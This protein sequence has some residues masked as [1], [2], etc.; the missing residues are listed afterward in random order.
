MTIEE[1]LAN[2]QDKN[3]V[4]IKFARALYGYQDTQEIEREG[5][6]TCPKLS[7]IRVISAKNKSGMRFHYNN[8]EETVNFK[9]GS[10]KGNFCQANCILI[11][12]TMNYTCKRDLITTLSEI[13]ISIKWNFQNTKGLTKQNNC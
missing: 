3:S 8:S 13:A 9:Y 11:G 2:N 1:I 4:E 10:I 7:N 12:A 6:L 5:M